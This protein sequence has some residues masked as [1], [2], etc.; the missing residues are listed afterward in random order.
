MLRGASTVSRCSWACSSCPRP[1]TGW[2]G[3]P[4]T[5]ATVRR[6]GRRQHDRYLKPEIDLQNDFLEDRLI[7]DVDFGAEWPG[8]NSRPNNIRGNSRWKEL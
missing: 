3:W 6:H 5:S 1:R 4:S 2:P 7:C 8:A